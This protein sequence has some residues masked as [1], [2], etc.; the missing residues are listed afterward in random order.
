[1]SPSEGRLGSECLRE[2]WQT[3]RSKN[4]G[5]SWLPSQLTHTTDQEGDLEAKRESHDSCPISD[6]ES[7]EYRESQSL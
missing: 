3:L 1:M 7:S 6:P 5:Q 2:G 4:S